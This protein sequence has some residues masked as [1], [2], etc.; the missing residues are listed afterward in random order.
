MQQEAT[1]KEDYGVSN[2]DRSGG[3]VGSSNTT[4]NTSESNSSGIAASIAGL[5]KEKDKTW[6]KTIDSSDCSHGEC[7]EGETA[8]VRSKVSA[9]REHHTIINEAYVGGGE[10][11]NKF[12]PSHTQAIRLHSRDNVYYIYIYIIYNIY[13]YI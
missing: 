7:S 2:L 6:K 4:Q 13:I 3:D 11:N 1:K 12:R 5:L 9:I 8:Q 10:R